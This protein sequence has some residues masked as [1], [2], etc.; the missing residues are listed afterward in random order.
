MGIPVLRTK[1]LAFALSGFMAGYAGVLPRLRHRAHLSTD[2]LRPDRLVP[3]HLHG[4]HRRAGLDPRGHPGRP[5]PGGP[6]GHLRDQPDH[7]VPD[8]RARAD[9]LHPLPAR[10]PGRGAPPARRRRHGGHPIGS[11]AL[12]GR[13]PAIAGAGRPP[14]P[15]RAPDGRRRPGPGGRRVDRD[16]GDGRHRRRGR[17]LGFPTGPGPPRRREPRRD[18]RR[19][20]R[21]GRRQLHGR[22]GV[23]RR[24]DR[25]QRVGQDDHC[26]T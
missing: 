6:A 17:A 15:S 16:R 3:G 2:H 25:R 12:L 8:Q 22:A 18:L 9:R 26:S 4:G 10:R 5:L 21:R 7:P 1:L 13:C 11:A 23:H 19:G 14:S 24:P 20:A